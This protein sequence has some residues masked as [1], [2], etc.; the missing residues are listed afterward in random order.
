MRTLA[1]RDPDQP[2]R[3]LDRHAGRARSGRPRPRCARA[4][5]GGLRA[6]SPPSIPELWGGLVD[7]AV[8]ADLGPERSGRAILADAASYTE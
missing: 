7:L 8:D 3:A 5:C 4:S 1:E 2:G 6:L